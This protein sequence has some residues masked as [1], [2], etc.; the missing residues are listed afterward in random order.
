MKKHDLLKCTELCGIPTDPE[1]ADL[2]R[3]ASVFDDAEACL[4]IGPD[5]QAP[6]I[7]CLPLL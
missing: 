2:K 5:V 6:C 1:Q 3:Q 4:L 7:M